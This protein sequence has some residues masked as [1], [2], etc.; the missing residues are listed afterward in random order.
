MVSQP[1]DNDFH[2]EFKQKFR[3]GLTGLIIIGLLVVLV[4]VYLCTEHTKQTDEGT[5]GT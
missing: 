5:E 3:Q 2:T 1:S 4:F